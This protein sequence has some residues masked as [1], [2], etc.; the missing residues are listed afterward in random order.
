MKRVLFFVVICLML[1]LMSCASVRYTPVGPP[2]IQ[3]YIFPAIGT[4]SSVYIG[5]P[6][7]REGRTAA[8]DAIYLK[9]KMGNIK[10][11]SVHY[12]GYYKLVGITKDGYTVY[13]HDVNYF[14][15]LATIYPQILEDKLGV[16]YLKTNSGKK[17]LEGSNFKK[18]KH[19]EDA[20]DEYKQ[21]IIYTGRE[22]NIIKFTYREFMND[23]ARPAFTIDATYD[24]KD[25][26][27]IRFKGA[28][29]E[30]IKADNQIITYKLL[31]GFKTTQE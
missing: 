24:M 15:G 11:G 13:Q 21:S 1:L 28:S 26:N 2:T 16:V 9:V 18:K 27:I 17:Q 23:M 30:V 12:A 6:L 20:S 3:E 7:V 29:L 25:D 8:R 19:V 14:N 4:E 22:N 5:E 10:T 31:S